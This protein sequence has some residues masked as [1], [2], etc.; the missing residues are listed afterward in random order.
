MKIGPK[1]TGVC[2]HLSA[3]DG[4][5]LGIV[6]AARRALQ[7]VGAAPEEIETF[8]EEALSGDYNHVLRTT[9]EWVGLTK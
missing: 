7:T 3:L 6:G 2:L 9:A 5:A 1:Y 8:V 4:N